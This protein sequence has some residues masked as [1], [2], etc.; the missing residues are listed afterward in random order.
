[1]SLRSPDVPGLETREE[2]VGFLSSVF[3]A[4]TEYSMIVLDAGG[5]ILMW[6]EGARRLYGYDAA[7]IVGQD[8][9]L[10]HSELDAR[11]GLPSQMMQGALQ[12]GKW[13]GTVDRRRRTAVSSPRVSCR[14]CGWTLAGSQ[15]VSC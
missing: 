1:M 9:S 8:Y 5:R 15:V 11:A 10:L 14:P 12:H 7:E 3:D 13:E 2:L 4:S 6:N